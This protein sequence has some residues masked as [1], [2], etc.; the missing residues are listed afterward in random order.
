M[1]ISLNDSPPIEKQT[2]V[3]SKDNDEKKPSMIGKK[4]MKLGMVKARSMSSLL[5]QTNI[6]LAVAE[7]NK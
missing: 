4:R 3:D 5:G 7:N 1:P 6:D 2:E